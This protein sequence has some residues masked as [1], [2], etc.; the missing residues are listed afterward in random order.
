MNPDYTLLITEREPIVYIEHSKVHVKDDKLTVY[1]EDGSV[2]TIPV[3]TTLILMMGAGTSISQSAA[4]FCAQNNLFLSFARG[5]S[6]IHSI[7][8]GGKWSPPEKIA[9]QALLHKNKKERLRIAKKLIE[10][11]LKKELEDFS[12]MDE[13]KSIKTIPKLLSF[14]ANMAK[15]TY[16]YLALSNKIDK[17]KR[18]NK[19]KEGVNSKI[20]LLNNA[21]YSYCTAVIIAFGFHPSLGFLHGQTRRGGLSFD[22]AD[23]F[24]YDLTL[25]PSFD[26]E[27]ESDKNLVMDFSYN[28]KKRRFR[29]IK[30]MIWVLRYINGEI[31]DENVE[32]ILDEY[33]RIR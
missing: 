24:K 10:L 17:F 2:E 12:F 18:D 4:I 14:E 23:I 9:N 33:S 8:Q 3:L 21:L 30:E 29:I 27:D 20:T 28:L 31:S 11:K 15:K 1:R 25:V 7:W 22:L 32:D 5:G 26:S 19:S 13:L 16:K 6:Y